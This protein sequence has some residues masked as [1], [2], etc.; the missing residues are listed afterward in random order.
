[1]RQLERVLLQREL[2][3]QPDGPTDR[4]IL[5]ARAAMR[6]QISLLRDEL[7][8][9]APAPHTLPPL[10]PTVDAATAARG[11]SALLDACVGCHQINA[12]GSGLA[13]MRPG[14]EQLVQANF[15]HREHTG[16]AGC[17]TCHGAAEQSNETNDILVPG[18]ASCQ[19]C[20]KPGGQGRST[21]ASC[22]TYH[23]RTGATL[24]VGRR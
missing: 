15:S 12:D 23:S 18:V 11:V 19:T 17:E 22:H 4:I 24:G 13:P 14:L 21:C 8:R 7:A 3:R 16:Q 2:G 20:H 6:T 10:A 1:M 5:S 9:L